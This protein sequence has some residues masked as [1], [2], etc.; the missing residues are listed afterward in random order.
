MGDKRFHPIAEIFPMMGTDE[1]RELKESISRGFDNRFPIVLYEGMIL[2]GRNRYIACQEL[3][4]NPEYTNFN[5]ND[6]DPIQFVV[7]ANLTR[8]HLTPGQKAFA[9]IEIKRLEAI[10][11]EKRQET[12]R[13][14][15][16]GGGK[17]ST[18][19]GKAR[20]KAAESVGINAR[21]I[22]IA[23]TIEDK[24]P[25]IAQ[26]VKDGDWTMNRAKNEYKRRERRNE[27]R[28]YSLS[29]K[30]LPIKQKEYSVIYAD[31]PWEYSSNAADK[32]NGIAENHYATLDIDGIKTFLNDS[33]IKPA[34]N[35]VL[36][37]WVTNP[38]LVKALSVIEAW[39]FEYKSNIV[40]VKT[41][42]KKPGI[43][44]YVRGR[45]ELLFICTRG[46]F[47]PLDRNVS[48]PIG[49]VLE[50]P[51]GK[52]SEK[53]ERVYGIIESLYP[54]CT[55]IELFAR[56]NRKGWDFIGNEIDI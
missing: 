56:K 2:D 27:V 9:G 42:L 13:F 25:D 5:G 17:F 21:Y 24:A 20:D 30:S 19:V 31:P 52:H 28:Q 29:V 11:A 15:S 4:I 1:A 51:I 49:S 7:R 26:K 50:E 22:D 6:G 48:P 23:E 55:Y 53:P 8:R 18:T 39:G 41:E 35:A 33:G 34:E 43:G 3:G 16:G 37:L 44:Y 46:N 38:F 12:T 54:G 45:H 14:G 32:H 10:E 40:W 47:T 36:F